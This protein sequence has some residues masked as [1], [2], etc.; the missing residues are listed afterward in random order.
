[1]KE[2]K[3]MFLVGLVILIAGLL[4]MQAGAISTTPAVQ[5]TNIATQSLV[6]NVLI[7]ADN[8][9]GDDTNP[10]VDRTSGGTLVVT[11]EKQT[12]IFVKTAPIVISEDQGETWT[13]VFEI[14]STAFSGSGLLNTPDITYS[15]DNGGFYIQAIDPEAMMYN[16]EFWFVDSEFTYLSGIGI[17]GT[18]SFDYVSGA[19]T[20][21]G[22]WSA[23]MDIESGHS[24]RGLGLG[25]YAYFP[26]DDEW[27]QP[28]DYDAGWAAG[29]YYDGESQ[30]VTSPAYYP[31]MDTGDR[32]FMV[33]Q[34]DLEEGSKIAMKATVTD[35]NPNSDTFVFTSGGGYQD[36]DKYADI[37]VWPWQQYVADGTNPD[38]SA[39]GSKV[40][41]VYEDGGD[42]KCSYS[43]DNGDTF[44][45]STVATGA[46]FPAVHVAGNTVSCAYVKD[47]NVFKVVSEDGG[48]T[49]G[50]PVQLNDVD[51]TVVAEPGAVDLNDLSV[52]WVDDRDGQKDIYTAAG[53]A[54]VPLISVKSI[55]KGFGVSAVIENTGT[56]DAIDVEGAITIDASLMI[57]GGNTPFTIDV[58]AGGETSVSTGF[59]LGLGP[60][61]ITV[62]AG[63]ASLQETGTVLG[64]F[65]L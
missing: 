25:W 3:N 30:L 23:G 65:V 37:E 2:L 35:L 12:D 22:I 41:V 56:A 47:G 51:G 4:C 27:L 57:L 63:D 21:I 5:R 42:V 40:A 28:V 24:P 53:G 26:D 16:Q 7:S 44:A 17:S 6:G 18:G 32:A 59:I 33:F 48:A 31:E 52:V 8:P 34:V 15:P 36:M 39:S 60:A 11:Y 19:I 1:M 14:D 50:D 55:G 58:A 20:S 46:G 64:P 29:F 54:A 9:D 43:S 13:P 61:T 38:V 62:T 45:V 49:W 10:K